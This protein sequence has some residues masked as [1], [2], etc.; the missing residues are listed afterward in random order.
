MVA[1][2]VR[3]EIGKIGKAL[4]TLV[5]ESSSIQSGNAASGAHLRGDRDGAVRARDRSLWLTRVVTG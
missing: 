4:Q 1:T 2:G 3:T 5:P